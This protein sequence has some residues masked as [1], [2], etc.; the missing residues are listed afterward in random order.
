MEGVT[1]AESESLVV[2]EAEGTP[3]GDGG[4]DGESLGDE[5]ILGKSLPL[6]DGG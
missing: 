5:G 1:E 2:E 4:S 6:G 3:S